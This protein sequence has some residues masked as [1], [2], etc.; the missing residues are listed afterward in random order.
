MRRQF[1]SVL[2]AV[3]RFENG[4]EIKEI[5]EGLLVRQYAD[6]YVAR[7][8]KLN[9]NTLDLVTTSL[10]SGLRWMIREGHPQAHAR[11]PSHKGRVYLAF[12]PTREKQWTI[13]VDSVNARRDDFGHA[14]FNG[15]YRGQFDEH[16]ISYEFEKRNRGAGHLEIDRDRVLPTIEAVSDFDHSVLSMRRSKEDSGYFVTEYDIQRKILFNWKKTPFGKSARIIGDEIPVDSGMNPRRIDILARD[17]RTND[18]IVIEIKRA[19]ASL[20]AIEQLLGYVGGLSERE[21]YSHNQIYG[22]LIAER[23]P[24]AVAKEARDVNISTFEIEYPFTFH[25][26]IK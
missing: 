15:K 9:N 17:N 1:D 23:I 18:Y 10:A 19:E 12:S 4:I 13:A 24:D 7:N 20:E 11:W 22:A 25:E 3:E 6:A 26:P 2:N 21:G 14:V 16:G 5:S 8:W